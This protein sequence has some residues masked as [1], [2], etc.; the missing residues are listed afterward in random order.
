MSAISGSYHAMEEFYKKFHEFSLRFPRR[1]N[2]NLKSV[3]VSGNYIFE[4]KSCHSS[5]ELS[6]CENVNYAFSVKLAKDAYDIIGHGRNTELLLEVVGAGYGARIMSCWWVENVQNVEYCFSVRNSQECFGCDGLKNK[7]FAILNKCY[8]KEQY[9]KIKATIV[10]ELQQKEEYGLFFP[11]V[12]AFFAYNETIAQDNMPVTKEEALAQ[13]YRWE[14]NVQMTI[15][16]ETMKPVEIPDHIKDIPDTIINEI[17]AC[18]S[19]GRNYKIIPA[20]LQF[21]RVMTLPLPRKCFYCRHSD[22]IRRRGPMKLYNRTC[23][24][25]K[26]PIKTNYAPERPEIVYCE[27]C[28]QQEVI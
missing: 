25:C 5:F 10:K 18:V 17:L 16:K 6:Y 27:A 21:Y 24:L 14:D 26:K 13:G 8:T 20:E 4:S 12:L 19:C 15:G 2:N 3:D 1:A 11:P 9:L 23:D 28:Y 7:K 22:R